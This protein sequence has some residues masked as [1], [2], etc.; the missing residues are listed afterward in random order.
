MALPDVRVS[1]QEFSKHHTML[2]ADVRI[3]GAETRSLSTR[4]KLIDTFL[5]DW[6][7]IAEFENSEIVTSIKRAVDRCMRDQDEIEMLV[8]KGPRVVSV[9]VEPKKT[10]PG[11]QAKSGEL[12]AQRS[13]TK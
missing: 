11:Y 7:D 2:M 1:D 9:K 5:A 8:P 4:D 10:K 3:N 6:S 13:R 12:R